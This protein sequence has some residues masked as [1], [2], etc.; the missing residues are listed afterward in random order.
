MY[1]VQRLSG[2]YHQNGERKSSKLTHI[3]FIRK[4]I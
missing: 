3:F 4:S 2:F 1:K